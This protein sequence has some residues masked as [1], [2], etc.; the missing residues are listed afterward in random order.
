MQIPPMII[1]PVCG[2]RNDVTV[3]FC[4]NC[5]LPLGA[6]RDPVRG[7]TT[8]RAE[9]PSD[10]GSGIAAII[11]LVAVVGIVGVA[12]LMIFRGFQ[13][14]AGG[15]GGSPGP[16]LVAMASIV[17]GA[18][19]GRSSPVASV[20]PGASVVIATSTP[21]ATDGPGT[22][23]DATP[24]PTKDPGAVA[25][26]SAWTCKSA[27][28]GDPFKGRWRIAR[29]SWNR[30]ATTDR[31]TLSLTRMSG[32]TKNGTSIEMAFMS[33]GKAASTYGVTRPLGDR[34]IVLTFDGPINVGTA[35]V[36][37]PGLLALETIDV[38]K[39]ASGVTHA[40][41]GVTGTGCARL[42]SPD[43]R[44]G[45]DSITSADLLLDVRR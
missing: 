8:K 20:E 42:N 25:T 24:R 23:G 17:P 3:R 16:S 39:D 21:K 13:A 11:G 14:N 4:R 12:G 1:C 2:L 26:V 7:T 32:G 28:I 31:L 44:S 9:L 6:P 30:G 33:P 43:W 27:A 35:M 5:G 29:A 10:R 45:S 19:A 15:A 18:T 41:I 36:A 38:R 40:V 34:A 22:G 37:S